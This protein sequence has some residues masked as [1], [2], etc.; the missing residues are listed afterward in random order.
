MGSYSS[1]KRRRLTVDLDAATYEWVGH[2]CVDWGISRR[3]LIDEALAMFME[4]HNT[5]A[6]GDADAARMDALHGQP[7]DLC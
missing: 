6:G 7:V 2:Y 3:H 5:T 1:D 4:T